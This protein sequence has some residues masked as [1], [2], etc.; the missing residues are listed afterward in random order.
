MQ[1]TIGRRRRE[2]GVRFS[3]RSIGEGSNDKSLN[4]SFAFLRVILGDEFSLAGREMIGE[5]VIAAIRRD[6]YF[7]FPRDPTTLLN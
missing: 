7:C 4:D 2:A 6:K 1:K 5:P 3:H